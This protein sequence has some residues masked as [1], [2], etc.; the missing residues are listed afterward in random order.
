[1][2]QEILDKIVINLDHANSGC[3]YLLNGHN[4]LKDVEFEVESVR[5]AARAV[6]KLAMILWAT[7]DDEYLDKLQKSKEE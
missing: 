4:C 5:H 3:E 2:K 7:F 1:M 6:T